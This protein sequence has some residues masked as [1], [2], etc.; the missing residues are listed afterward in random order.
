MSDNDANYIG[1]LLEE[2]R[3]QNKAVLE[4]VGD[5][6]NHVAKIP[7]IEET[8]TELKEDMKIIKVAITDVSKQQ[9]DHERRITQLE[10]A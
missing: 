1:V 6:Q 9:K 3:G 8:V 7:Y 4:A 2:I 10:A 5:M